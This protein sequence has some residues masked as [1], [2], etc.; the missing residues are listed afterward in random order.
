[1]KRPQSKP[2]QATRLA[3]LCALALGS[4]HALAE[5]PT[6][7][8]AAAWKMH[9]GW[10]GWPSIGNA[11][12]DF[13]LRL[14]Q[15]DRMGVALARE[16]LAKGTNP[17]LRALAQRIVDNGTADIATLEGW[18]GTE[19]VDYANWPMRRGPMR[20]EAMDLNHDGRL[21]STEVNATHPWHEHFPV[22]DTNHDGY[23]SLAEMNAFRPPMRPWAS[24]DAI[25]TNNDGTISRNE[26]EAYRPV[27]RGSMTFEAMDLNHDG[28]LDNVEIGA[29]HPWHPYFGTADLNHDGW[30]SVTE[31]DK[32][33]VAN[34]PIR[35]ELLDLNHDGRLDTVAEVRATDPWYP[36]FTTADTNHDGYVSNAEAMAWNAARPRFDR[37]GDGDVDSA[38]CSGWGWHGDDWHEG[39]M[40]GGDAEHM[41]PSF[42][43]MDKNGDGYLSKDELPA[44]NWVLDH[45]TATDVNG[46]GRISDAEFEAHHEMMEDMRH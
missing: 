43:G 46:D 28:R 7:A 6:A 44:S 22:A 14:R 40:A 41:P 10:C 33:R 15:H 1:M 27:R 29:T 19:H 31:L 11:D 34:A 12:Q 5:T 26:L 13:A 32:W 45:F 35:F 30:I 38:D 21:D 9:H 23:V 20:F 2:L 4:A 37:D 3:V 42:S 8:D 24:F 18:L 25:D 39:D 16:E 36:Y 17:T